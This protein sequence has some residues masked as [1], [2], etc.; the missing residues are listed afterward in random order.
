MLWR[1]A[2]EKIYFVSNYGNVRVAFNVFS[3]SIPE[4]V[5]YPP[6]IQKTIPLGMHS[7]VSFFKIT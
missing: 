7:R 5:G 6:K 4:L 2:G 1:E 3:I